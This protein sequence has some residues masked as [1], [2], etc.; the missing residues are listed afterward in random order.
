MES[1]ARAYAKINLHLAV[2]KKRPDGYHQIRSLF[3][4]VGLCDVLSIDIAP[5]TR[6]SVSVSGLEGI[7]PEGTDTMTKACNL[8]EEE[9]RLA[10]RIAI[11]I[12]KNI[13]SRAGLGGGSSDAAAVLEKLQSVAPLSDPAAT[14]ARVGSDVPFFLSGYP[15]AWCEGRGEIVT[16]VPYGGSLWAALAMP[17]GLAVSTGKAYEELDRLPRD[18]GPEKEALSLSLTKDPLGRDWRNDF[19]KVSATDPWYRIARAAGSGL[20]GYGALSGSGS[21]WFFLVR[22]KD[23]QDLVTFQRRMGSRASSLWIVPVARK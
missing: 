15:L 23:R 1:E 20:R 9:T 10:V 8:W 21:C 7:C 22:E 17:G 4:R 12:K 16:E 14:A 18:L 2:G 13:P 5:A 19:E 11:R 3:A 6:Y